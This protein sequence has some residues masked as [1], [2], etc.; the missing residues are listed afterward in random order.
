MDQTPTGEFHIVIEQV[1]EPG[2]A[3]KLLAETFGFDEA[4]GRA[5]F[6]AAPIVLFSRLTKGE[7][8]AVTPRLLELSR[9]GFVFR[10]TARTLKIPRI[11]WLVR[12]SFPPTGAPVVRVDWGGADFTCPS[13]GES[14][15]LIRTTPLRFAEPLPE[16]LGER[17]TA[18]PS[19]GER[20]V[21]T[22]DEP[23]EQTP[24]PPPPPPPA[25]ASV[26]A[27]AEALAD[28]KP[29]A[30]PTP[31]DEPVSE[32]EPEP[33]PMEAPVEPAESPVPEDQ[34]ILT[35][36][37]GT[38]LPAKDLEIEEALPESD[39]SGP[40]SK[41][42]EA[43]LRETQRMAA[44]P[45][46]PEQPNPPSPPE[47]PAAVVSREDSGERFNVFIPEVKDPERKEQA[48]GLLAEIQG[49]SVEEARKLAQR[50]M[51]PVA[52][53]VTQQEAEGIL[54]RFRRIKVFGRMMRVVRGVQT[55]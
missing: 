19:P 4:I 9:S 16:D 39:E 30:E 28:V 38:A 6:K 14:F 3:A 5:L 35:P 24:Q 8:K 15:A 29:E 23:R 36:S 45:S 2:V 31:E 48:V 50:L 46:A 11:N 13:C 52:R 54:S 22:R 53:D 18:A 12:P 42:F 27:E 55:S 44:G 34:P 33:I 7:I 21:G 51:I 25:E 17:V 40:L 41:A 10:I 37:H 20:E 47:E 43:T 49:I 1:P 26:L 32:I